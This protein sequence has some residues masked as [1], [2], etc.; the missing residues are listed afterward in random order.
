MLPRNRDV[1]VHIPSQH[2]KYVWHAKVVYPNLTCSVCLSCPVLSEVCRCNRNLAEAE[3]L[4]RSEHIRNP[5]RLLYC[6]P[7]HVKYSTTHLLKIM[8]TK[9]QMRWDID[10]IVPET[11]D[12]G[13][14][15]SV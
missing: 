10:L 5:Y 8:K 1:P 3:T 7:A 9:G 15:Q 13:V 14:F 4:H 11:A 6:P 2:L 12:Y